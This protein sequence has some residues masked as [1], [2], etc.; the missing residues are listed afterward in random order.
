MS[1]FL[2]KIEIIVRS[3]PQFDGFNCKSYEKSMNLWMK[4]NEYMNQKTNKNLNDRLTDDN[5]LWKRKNDI[6]LR[7]SKHFTYKFVWQ[8]YLFIHIY[9][10]MGSIW[11]FEWNIISMHF[12]CSFRI[13]RAQSLWKID[14]DIIK[15]L[16]HQ[17]CSCIEKL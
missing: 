3:K 12:S 1:V 11:A 15:V 2:N 5:Q 16:R 7:C 8:K 9:I 10:R 6:K 4:E 14:L 17:C 13:L